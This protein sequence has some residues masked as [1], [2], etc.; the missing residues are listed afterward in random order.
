[1]SNS[2]SDRDLALLAGFQLTE[3]DVYAPSNEPITAMPAS[4]ESWADNALIQL[5]AVGGV[6]GLLTLTVA[7]FVQ[8]L[9]TRPAS[10]VADVLPRD[11][12]SAL[13][14][15]G[16]DDMGAI[17]ADLA[18]GEQG[19]ELE[20][21]TTQPEQPAPTPV[22]APSP[23]P[24]PE[25]RPARPSPPVRQYAPQAP[26]PARPVATVSISEP[27]PAA[28]AVEE[29]EEPETSPD[30]EPTV[31]SEAVSEEPPEPPQP[32][33]VTLL[34]GSRA[35][36]VLQTPLAVSRG[37]AMRG[38]VK[39]TEPL[40][41]AD[42]SIALPTDT[43]LVVQAP[44]NQNA[45][46]H[47]TVTAVILDNREH[48]LSSE[49]ILALPGSGPFT[50][51]A[52]TRER[53]TALNIEAALLT[54]LVG[55]LD[56]DDSRF[57]AGTALDIAEQLTR[58]QTAEVEAALARA[59]ALG[60]VIPAETELL[61]HINSTVSLPAPKAAEAI[62]SLHQRF[63]NGATPPNLE[64]AQAAV[65]TAAPATIAPRL[66]EY[67]ATVSAGHGETVNFLERGETLVRV[68]L[69]DP[70][71][72]AVD[73]DA[74]IASGAAGILHI[75]L[76]PESTARSTVLTVVTRTA[77]GSHRLH[78]FRIK[79]DDATSAGS[80]E[81]PSMPLPAIQVQDTSHEMH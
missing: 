13:A 7:L 57:L 61:I 8:T 30:P 23:S 4:Q 19:R 5:A 69:D 70:E 21:L 47:L 46:T 81:P 64:D 34:T 6:V 54:G 73:Y 58:Q 42:G 65:E 50:D 27:A 35:A 45:L 62:A 31:P 15:T 66:N 51:A 1:M 39:L 40:R 26:P 79:R 48:A 44:G 36:A 55:V 74:P 75:R 78:R 20:A 77:E 18:F 52:P 68:W 17:K 76:L 71:F 9:F 22:P 38:L 60:M 32:P 37:L 63:P 49:S 25:P 2:Y 12:A 67:V 28:P 24:I 80:A 33:P 29:V 14:S 53:E 59:Q 41:A 56:I 16:G 11:E 10:E 3:E 43:L 72:I